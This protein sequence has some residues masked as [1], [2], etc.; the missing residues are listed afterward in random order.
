[1]TLSTRQ[2][3]AV[4][5]L[6][7]LAGPVRL[8]RCPCQPTPLQEAFLRLPDLEVLLGGAA[9]VGK[10]IGLLMSALSYVDVPGY[11]ALLLRPTLAEFELPGGLIELSRDWLV[12][13]GAEWSGETRT[14]RFPGPAR[15]GAGGA[16]LRFGYLDGV[17]D[18]ARYS[19]SSFSFLGYDELIRFSEL[20]YRRM[21]RLLR[22]PSLGAGLSTSPDGLTLADVPRRV[23]A[24]SNPGGP[25]H[26]WVR[27]YFV[28]PT[29]RHDGV[30]FLPGRLAE[31]P[32]LD[33]ESY[34]ATLALLPT[35]ER[36][37]L[38]EGDWEIPDEGELFRREWFQEIAR[39]PSQTT[40]AVR[41]WDLAATVRSDARP[42]PDY[43]VGLRIDLDKNGVFYISDIVRV[44]RAPGAVEALVAATAA[45][46][47]E[48]VTIAIEQEPGSAGVA[49][50]DRY[51]RKVLHGY[52]V[53]RY[54]PSGAKDVRARNVAAAAENGLIRLIHGQN[55][56]EFL[57]EV[58]AFPHAPHDDCV[59]ALAGAH[60][61]ISRR[62]GE[63]TVHRTKRRLD[64]RA[65]RYY[66]EL[67]ARIGVP[68]YSPH[69]GAN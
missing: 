35:V 15:S 6:L 41:F 56:S 31:N 49:V 30:V 19:G 14:W 47:G 40:R 32:Y 26:A 27:S 9:G 3:Q 23:R 36:Q 1:M 33:Q 46:D 18:V 67:A 11:H 59:D 65:P 39:M 51:M 52:T 5:K 45:R 16:T 48:A 53:R 29:T 44:R 57:D 43:T 63:M 24:T 8:R 42:D 20:G 21:L 58:C 37:R 69:E 66:L 34:R 22:Q 7:D 62:T 64:N 12:G 60:Q 13:S 28:D 54:R 25:H 68:L 55:S 10:T 4:E 17:T 61:V 2:H 50:I 38:L